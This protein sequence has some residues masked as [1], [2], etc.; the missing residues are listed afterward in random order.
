MSVRGNRDSPLPVMMLVSKQLLRR[1]DDLLP[2]ATL[3]FA[4]MRDILIEVAFLSLRTGCAVWPM[5]SS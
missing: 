4:G 2:L 3:M 5:A 1:A